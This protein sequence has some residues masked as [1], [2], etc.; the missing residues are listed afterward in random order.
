MFDQAC[1]KYLLR[2]MILL[3]PFRNIRHILF[4]LTG[5]LTKYYSFNMCLCDKIIIISKI[6]L[7]MNTMIYMNISHKVCITRLIVGQSLDQHK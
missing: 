2:T 1:K 3:A 6:L 5:A 4:S 7:K